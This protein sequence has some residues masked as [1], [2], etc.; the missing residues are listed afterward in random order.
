MTR[1]PKVVLASARLDG[2]GGTVANHTW[3]AGIETVTARYREKLEADERWEEA[4]RSR[5]PVEPPKTPKHKPPGLDYRKPDDLLAAKAADGMKRGTYKNSTDA[6]RSLAKY[7]E[8]SGTEE[9]RAARIALRT[10]QL[11][12]RGS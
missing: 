10:R 1:R 12:S 6:G 9:S 7:A 11:I 3:R 4:V 2:K 5:G 8:G